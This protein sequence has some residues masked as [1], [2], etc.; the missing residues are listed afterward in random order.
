MYKDWIATKDPV[1]ER[2][3]KN[4]ASA[5]RKL[6]NKSEAIYFDN[7]CNIKLQSIKRV[8]KNLNTICN[9]KHAKNSQKMSI[10]KIMIDKVTV[11][12]PSAIATHFNEY[13]C[14]LGQNLAK[15]I[16]VSKYN[17]ETYMKHS[18]PCTFVCESVSYN[19]ILNA[20][21]DFN[22]SK[23]SSVDNFSNW[24]LK[25]CK[26]ELVNPL[27]HIFNL[28]FSQGIFPSKLKCAKVIPLFKGNDP[29]LLTNY[30][31]ISLLSPFS[32]LL[33][34][35]MSS[36]IRSFLTKFNVLYDYQFGFRKVYSTKFALLDAITFIENESY[37]NMQVLG[38]FLDY[39]KA[40]DT[41]SIDILISKLNFYGIRGHVLDW[42]KSYLYNRSQF[43]MVNNSFSPTLTN[44]YGVPQGS[45]LGPL[46]FLL[47]IND[48]ANS[49]NLG[50]FKLF[51]DD[52][53]IF[54][55]A[56]TMPEIFQI[57]NNVLSDVYQWT[58]ANKL[59]INFE[60]T[61]YMLFKVNA[62]NNRVIKESNFQIAINNIVINRVNNIKYLG[63]WIDE[64]LTWNIHVDKLVSKVQTLIGIFFRKKSIIPLSCRKNLYFA[65]IYSALLYGIEVYGKATKCLLNPLLIKCN[66][67]LRLLQN[68]PRL[69][70]TK[71]LYSSYDTLP[72]NLLY[73]FY[74]YKLMHSITYNINSVPLVIRNLFDKNN[75]I[76]SHFTRSS[77]LFH[78][79]GSI[80]P[81]AI[82]FIGPSLWFKLP[83]D[84]RE[85]TNSSKFLK[86][87]KQFL[88]GES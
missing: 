68:K 58:I 17:Y 84:L 33:E 75:S 44:N 83:N 8:W 1:L 72:M 13:F 11:E 45:V 34:K 46:L 61:N 85:C 71:S 80:S 74:I 38:L 70:N 48:I 66:F 3:Y 62:K 81:E 23:C 29:F 86:L 4:Y 67:L 32:K 24:L 54:I 30:R 7:K 2:I 9:F 51:A 27:L 55:V 64:N 43:T 35:L 57:A 52:T 42:F 26:F 56:K 40:F 50:K 21:Y 6:I 79:H 82:N 28:S 14:N 77:Q 88:N 19:E 20:I 22:N 73:K 5:L 37:N 49:S 53:N 87:C 41:V 63:V 15:S 10:N 12:E 78:V 47:Y 76:H 69:T 60:K 18:N 65:L 59:S 16:P 25:H 36:R 39:K 31:P